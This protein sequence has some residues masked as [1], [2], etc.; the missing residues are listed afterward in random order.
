MN[1][2]GQLFVHVCLLRVI[3]HHSNLHLHSRCSALVNLCFM[4]SITSKARWK[5]SFLVHRSDTFKIGVESKIELGSSLK[6]TTKH[7]IQMTATE[8]QV[9]RANH[10]TIACKAPV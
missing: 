6:Q 5:M 8:I 7:T 10:D 2:K 4:I 1:F 9:S 3:I